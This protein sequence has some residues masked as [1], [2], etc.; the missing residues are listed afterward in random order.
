MAR[1][2][3]TIR[4]PKILIAL[5]LVLSGCTDEQYDEIPNAPLA[6]YAKAHNENSRF[7][8]QPDSLKILAI[9]NSFTENSVA[10][11]PLLLQEHHITNVTLGKICYGGASLQNHERFFRNKTQ[12]Y[13]FQLKLPE[14]PGWHPKLTDTTIEEAVRYC[15]WDII[16]L[17]QASAVSGL[18]QRYQPYLNRLIE[19][20]LST[21]TNPDLTIVW[22]M[23]WPYSPQCSTKAFSPYRYQP[24]I[25]YEA[26]RKATG[27]ILEETGIRYCIPSG[28]CINTLRNHSFYKDST[29]FTSDGIHIDH[30]TG[31]YALAC[32][33]YQTLI[34]PIYQT[35]L[36]ESSSM[37]VSM[38]EQSLIHSIVRN[39]VSANP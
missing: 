11:L 1:T 6:G 3:P 2:V 21:A 34:R 39:T 14:E 22:H 38:E 25:M 5:C 31:Q 27:I 15:E 32:T 35:E 20:I 9:G 37:P 18:P 23:T 30:P 7:P 24:G 13:Q 10:L 17:Q 4:C 16:V 8:L 33:W 36:H 29:D 26:I 12:A 28:E 19:H